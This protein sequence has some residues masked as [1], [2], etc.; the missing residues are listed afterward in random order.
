MKHFE[1]FSWSGET[2]E[3]R[4]PFDALSYAVG[5]SAICFADLRDEI[6][7]QIRGLLGLESINAWMSIGTRSFDERI[8]VL[9]TLIRSHLENGGW[10]NTGNASPLEY[11]SELQGR[12]RRAAS[13]WDCVMHS[14]RV[15]FPCQGRVTHLPVAKLVPSSK[16]ILREGEIMDVADIIA[17]VTCDLKQF[18]LD[19]DR[20][21]GLHVEA[22]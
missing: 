5:R 22:P 17:C 11:W 21:P 16:H 10:F 2:V 15:P 8:S 3:E 1:E 9:D 13:F 6:T 18:F 14:S 19:V 12:C 4:G 7:G 20:P